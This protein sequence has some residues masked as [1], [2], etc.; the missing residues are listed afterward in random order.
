MEIEIGVNLAKLIAFLAVFGLGF[1][2]IVIIN[3][4]IGKKQIET[5][6]SLKTCSICKEE[7]LK[8]MYFPELGICKKCFEK[9]ERKAR[10]YAESL[11]SK[12]RSNK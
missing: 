1:A 12:R 5:S 10:I 2:I 3:K 9:G 7:M 6:S 11:Y 4:K 8:D